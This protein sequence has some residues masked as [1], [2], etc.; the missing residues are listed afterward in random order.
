VPPVL[1]NGPSNPEGWAIPFLFTLS[2]A[3]SPSSQP[4]TT[5]SRLVVT[6]IGSPA[7]G[8]P[9][10]VSQ[11]GLPEDLL[12]EAA[13]RVGIVS[14]VIAG[15]LVAEF[16]LVHFLFGLP[17][18]LK[19]EDVVKLSQWRPVFDV[20]GPA[21]IVASLALFWYAR[22]SRRGPRFLLALALGY[23]VFLALTIG[24]LNYA[25]EPPTGVSWIAVLIVLFAAIV[26]SSP[27]KMLITALVAASMDPVAARM[28]QALGRESVGMQQAFLLAIPNYLCALVA[29]LISHIITRL[30]REVRK[31]R[32]MGSYVLGERIGSGGMGEVWEA[33]HRFLAR[34]AAIKLIKPEVLSAV[35]KVQADVLVQRFRREARAAANLRS[36]HTIQLYDF[37]VAS[38]GT[39]YYVMELLN[40]MDLQS[41]VE[42]HGPIPPARTIHILQQVCESLA[43][44]HDRGLIHRDIKPANI[45][46]CCMGHYFDYVKVLDFGLV[47]SAGLDAKVDSA[48]TAPNMVTGTPA[49][50]SPESAMGQPVDQRSDIYALGCVA[51]WMLTGRYVFEG[52][53]V[54]QIMARH[55]HTPP[56]PPSLY[57][58]FR[59]PPELDQIV[60]A[61]LAKEPSDRPSSA[62]DLADLLAQC[63]VS[64]QWTRDH[65]RLW[66]ESR[67]EPEP[68]VSL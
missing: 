10:P 15:L 64:Q 29:P 3:M 63:E 37:G 25:V 4:R 54:V 39:F 45:Q 48:L 53:G 59:I 68:A 2:F 16:L 52:Q 35:T 51:F 1:P 42:E 49:Y 24:V 60:L 34:P 17:G 47:K 50:L 14:L 6:E 8:P 7:A 67:L 40:G 12:S 13:H 41:L 18:T 21:I 57:S 11:R 44:A 26:P 20:I 36:P 9:T 43:E 27:P 32:E 31:A 23:E 38:D 62:R 33:K 56:E 66:W 22:R 28:W 46:V 65:A 30:G 58:L 61:C 5:D 19:P 55:I